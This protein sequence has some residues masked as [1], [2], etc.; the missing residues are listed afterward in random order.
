[1]AFL[2]E[3]G[4]A[5]LATYVWSARLCHRWTRLAARLDTVSVAGAVSRR[6]FGFVSDNA[7]RPDNS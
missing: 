6:L 5:I 1:V 7:M 4:A 2:G 3:A